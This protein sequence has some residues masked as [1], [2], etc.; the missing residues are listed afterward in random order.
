[1]KAKTI[2]GNFR[3]KTNSALNDFISNDFNPVMVIVFI[4]DT[5]YS[6]HF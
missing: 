1:M 4:D 5:R 3:D 2:A 6:R